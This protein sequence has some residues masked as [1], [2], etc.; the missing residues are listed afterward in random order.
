MNRRVSAAFNIA[1]FDMWI[2][3]FNHGCKRTAELPIT[4]ADTELVCKIARLVL[5]KKNLLSDQCIL[6]FIKIAFSGI[7]TPLPTL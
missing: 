7:N 3:F 4:F 5:V 2:T 6:K 1:S